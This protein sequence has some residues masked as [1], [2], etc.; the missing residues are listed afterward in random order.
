VNT[1]PTVLLAVSGHGFG[2]AVRCAEVA[3]QL[4]ARGAVV[5]VRTDAP[6]WL[7][8]HRAEYL[9]SPGWP[10]DVG[11]AQHDGLDLDIGETWRRWQAF[12]RDFEAR[13]E[14]EA[15]LLRQGGID[16]VLGDIPPLAFAAA[17]RAGLRSAA[18]GNFT[19]DWIYAA[20][21]GFEPIIARIQAAYRQ[22][23]VLF[24]LPFHSTSA[25]AFSAFERVE[26]I[27]LIARRAAR[28]RCQVR[29]EIG[30][31]EL[32]RVVL[33]SFGAFAAEGLDVRALGQ[34]ADYT[35][36]LTPPLSL[37][38]GQLP[39]NVMSLN[40]SPADYVSLVGACDVVVTKPGYGIVADCLANRVAVLF[41]D[42]GPFREYDVL[43]E[44][45]PRLG[46]ARYIPR[47]ELLAGR[48]GP[49]LDALQAS[50][51]AWTDQPINGA[52]VLANR[53]LELHNAPKEVTFP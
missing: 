13:A 47:G 49:H 50:E 14:A 16:L 41:T 32:A 18:V 15:D 34:L 31:P 42:R 43:A 33:L 20:W 24:R 52:E 28:S 8:P 38:V 29:S 1:T 5:K 9:P 40:Q 48:L 46:H 53:V 37:G 12:A 2:H 44:A 10:L 35:F 11:V 39:A 22:A 26:D 36:V 51:S 19:W 27:P 23:G 30:L 17:T 3:R 4:L 25:D 6:P 21:P 45:L 7:F